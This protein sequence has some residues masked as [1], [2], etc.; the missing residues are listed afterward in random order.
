VTISATNATAPDATQNF[1]LTV[2]RQNQT[3]SFAGPAGQAFTATP[4]ALIASASSVA[5]RCHSASSTPAVC[6][7]S[8]K[9]CNTDLR[10]EP[11]PLPRRNPATAPIT[12]QRT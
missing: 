7:V 6:G 4:V 12:R 3:I 2:V 8:G 5:K 10:P 1:T 9:Q 11:A